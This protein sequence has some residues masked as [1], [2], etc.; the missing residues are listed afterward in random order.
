MKKSSREEGAGEKAQANDETA[1]L[2]DFEPLDDST[3]FDWA[4]KLRAKSLGASP[5]VPAD[6]AD[7]IARKIIYDFSL[8]FWHGVPQNPIV[9]GWLV[10][11]LGEI[12]ENRSAAEAFGLKK[13][14]VG[15]GPQSGR[16]GTPVAAWVAVAV[17]RGH[18]ITEAEQ[19]AADAFACST[20]T[21]QR[22]VAATTLV[23]DAPLE[24]YL[25][26]MKNSRSLPPFKSG[27]GE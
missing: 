18:S 11:A 20:R 12:L 1:S 2:L 15:R 4:G 23:P 5:S 8:R 19:L 14:P 16:D 27:A 9:M 21:V 10:D 26:G 24:E 6:E 3:L 22:H 25:Q 7:E 17:R 13:R